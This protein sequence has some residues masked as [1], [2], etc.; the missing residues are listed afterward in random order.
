V[1]QVSNAVA[2]HGSVGSGWDGIDLDVAEP[3]KLGLYYLRDGLFPVLGV[4]RNSGTLGE[5]NAYLLPNVTPDGAPTVDL[6]TEQGLFLWKDAQGAWH[7]RATAGTAGVLFKGEI[8]SD[9]ALVSLRGNSLE[10]ADVVDYS[11]PGRVRFELGVAP[12]FKDELIVGFAP[13]ADIDLNLDNPA[14]LGLVFI[15]ADKWPIA[16]LPLDLSGW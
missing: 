1:G 11:V 4:N 8:I 5:A 9:M 10:A 3:G 13:G 12:G 14:Q 6:A 7:L 16:N 15:G 2:V